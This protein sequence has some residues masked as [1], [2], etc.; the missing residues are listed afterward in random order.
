M[1]R[2]LHSIDKYPGSGIGLAMCKTIVENHGGEIWVESE[3]GTGSTF[4]FTLSRNYQNL[5]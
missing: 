5:K 2:R 3:P 4:K 1:F